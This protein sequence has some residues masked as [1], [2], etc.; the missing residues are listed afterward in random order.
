[1]VGKK[2][3]RNIRVNRFIFCDDV[4][5][6]GGGVVMWFFICGVLFVMDIIVGWVV[7]V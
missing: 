3:M 4:D 1:M 7:V 6:R 5:F 2:L